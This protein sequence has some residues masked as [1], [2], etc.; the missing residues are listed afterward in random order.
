MSWEQR[1]RDL[2]IAGGA[3][4]ATAC[5]SASPGPTPTSDDATTGCGNA[6]PDPCCYMLS[7][8]EGPDS[9][10]YVLCEQDRT[11]CESHDGFLGTSNDGALGCYF[12]PE[13]GP[14]D[15]S[16]DD[17]LDFSCCGNINP[18]PCCH[19]CDEPDGPVQDPA[20][21]DQAIACQAE[22]GTYSNDIQQP[23]GNFAVGCLFPSRDADGDG[24][25]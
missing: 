9:S 23:D 7:G 14:S 15:A 25:D 2:V 21:C 8:G 12:L 16:P 5:A 13:A 3:M 11:T 22:G 17:I 20:T 19:P 6:N 24:H 4:A 18:D 1:F 10:P